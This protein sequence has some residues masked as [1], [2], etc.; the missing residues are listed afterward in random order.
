MRKRYVYR[1]SHGHLF[2][3]SLWAWWPAAFPEV[4]LGFGRYMRCPVGN[5]WA[6]VRRVNETELTQQ[7]RE[8]LKL[9]EHHDDRVVGTRNGAAGVV[10]GAS[11]LVITIVLKS[12]WWALV[13]VAWVAFFGTQFVLARR[14]ARNSS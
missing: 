7:E 1:C 10:I 2:S 3:W 4:K 13:C 6:V 5:H 9:R 14:A 11:T 8:T 12:W